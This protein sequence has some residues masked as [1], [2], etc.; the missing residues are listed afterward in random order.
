M[1]SLR[2]SKLWLSVCIE[3]CLVLAFGLNSAL[4][5]SEGN[6]E[7]A[8]QPEEEQVQWREK[9]LRSTVGIPPTQMDLGNEADLFT[10]DE[11]KVEQKSK[12]WKLR[13]KA[14][15]R[16]TARLS[17]GDRHD[18]LSGIEPH[19]PPRIAGLSSGDW[20]HLGLVPNPSAKAYFRAG[21]PNLNA[22]VILGGQPP[23]DEGFENVKEMGWFVDAYLTLKFPRAF[24]HRGGV[25]WT[26]GSFSHR[27]GNAGKKTTGYYRTYLFG[28]THVL[29]SVIT[30][31][32]DLTKHWELIIEHG[33]GAKGDVVPWGNLY[34]D[35]PDATVANPNPLFVTDPDADFFQ[36]DGDQARGSNFLHHAHIQL[37]NDYWLR[38]GAH[39]LTSWTPNDGTRFS[40]TVNRNEEARLDVFGAEMNLDLA[41]GSGF[42][43]WSRMNMKDIVPLSNAIQNLHASRGSDYK[44]I[45]LEIPLEEVGPTETRDVAQNDSGTVDTV[46]F[47]Y[48]LR[49]GNVFMGGPEIDLGAYG[50]YA[51]VTSEIED[52]GDTEIDYHR[53]KFGFEAM[54]PMFSFMRTMFRYDR[55]IDDFDR[56]EG[57]FHAIS[58]RLMFYSRNG[59][60][61]RIMLNYTYF[62]YGSQVRVGSPFRSSNFKPDSH[63]LG[64]SAVMSL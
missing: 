20:L 18:G 22:T 16:G 61:E 41:T 36:G 43:G 6:S 8:A 40:S 49:L 59:S 17:L 51:H 44:K 46:L 42:I 48:I 60:K 1:V 57:S 58:P 37:R 29:G 10:D 62:M 32:I 35:P 21:T 31:D 34:A 11:K 25:S 3:A 39:Y 52:A 19:A 55:V 5:Q 45:Y 38:L 64:L 50:M 24:G 54:Y 56:P 26:A 27:Y 47:Q 30:A 9:P 4:A 23:F 28:K 7:Q 53:L 63:F 2:I 13:M 14:F 33:V 12:Q 15:V